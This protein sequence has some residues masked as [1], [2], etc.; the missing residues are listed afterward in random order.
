MLFQAAGQNELVPSLPFSSLIA[1]VEGVGRQRME[2][3][4][5]GAEDK[6]D[7]V[8]EIG[9]EAGPLG[10]KCASEPSGCTLQVD[11]N[12][13][14]VVEDS[15]TAVLVEVVPH[16]AVAVADDKVHL[17]VHTAVVAVVDKQLRVKVGGTGVALL[18]G[19][20]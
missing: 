19:W 16:T 15:E 9:A 17:V 14:Q 5:G 6:A 18:H 2:V 4:A 10:K 8:A 3:A 20:A 12:A 7:A 1:E 11:C 13:P